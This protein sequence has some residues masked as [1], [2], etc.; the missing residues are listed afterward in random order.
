LPLSILDGASMYFFAGFLIAYNVV[1]IVDGS[2]GLFW[3]LYVGSVG[4]GLAILVTITAAD[5][6][7]DSAMIMYVFVGIAL[8]IQGVVLFTCSIHTDTA[9]KVYFWLGAGLIIVA[10][11]FQIASKTGNPLCTSSGAFS[12]TSLIQGHAIWHMLSAMGIFLV[13]FYFRHQEPVSSCANLPRLHFAVVDKPPAGNPLEEDPRQ[14][15]PGQTPA[16]VG[17]KPVKFVDPGVAMYQGRPRSMRKHFSLNGAVGTPPL[18]PD[19]A[20]FRPQGQGSHPVPIN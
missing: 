15:A 6:S 11:G 2:D 8:I 17:Y 20:E 16:P 18:P 3:G 10:T 4:L 5:P 12:P 13:Y 7:F 9:G 14:P 19:F 1:R